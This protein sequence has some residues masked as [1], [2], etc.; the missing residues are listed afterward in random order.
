[1]NLR[2]LPRKKNVFEQ[3]YSVMTVDFD[4]DVDQNSDRTGKAFHILFCDPEEEEWE[5]YPRTHYFFACWITTV[6]STK[7]WE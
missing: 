2:V 5:C 3:G 7:W 1:M 6:T 4:Y